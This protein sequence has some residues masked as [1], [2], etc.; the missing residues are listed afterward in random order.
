MS[1]F[2]HLLELSEAGKMSG[3]LVL[4][5][6]HREQAITIIFHTTCCFFLFV[7]LIIKLWLEILEG[8]KVVIFSIGTNT[9]VNA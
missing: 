6:A 4:T 7:C 9:Q 8:Y 5:L 1:L 3:L 2:A